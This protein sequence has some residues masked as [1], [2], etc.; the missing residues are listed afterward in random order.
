M[1][2]SKLA[3]RSWTN[4]QQSSTRQQCQEPLDLADNYFW[5]PV[6]EHKLEA[7]NGHSSV[8]VGLAGGSRPGAALMSL[9]TSLD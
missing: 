1:L 6:Q 9:P 3:K 5:T 7:R 2:P 4:T 8:V